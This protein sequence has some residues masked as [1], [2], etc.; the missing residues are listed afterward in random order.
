MT[1]GRGADDGDYDS[2]VIPSET[3]A[4]VGDAPLVECDGEVLVGHGAVVCLATLGG[5]SRLLG[6]GGLEWRAR[7]NARE[8]DARLAWLPRSLRDARSE[9]RAIHLF[10]RK[11]EA[12]PYETV[13][14]R[15]HLSSWG[16][17]YGR[18]SARFS[19]E[20]TL[21]PS[22]ALR[23]GH[24]PPPEHA[25]LGA[26]L[27]EAIQ[28][29]T[30]VGRR[31]A[32]ARRFVESWRGSIPS[33]VE[34]DPSIP[35]TVAVW[36]ALHAELSTVNEYLSCHPV[37]WTD[38]DGIWIFHR[39]SQSA[40]EWGVR[41]RDLGL[42]DPPVV[43]RLDGDWEDD[44]P[45]LSRWALGFVIAAEAF[46]HRGVRGW[47]HLDDADAALRR[48]TPMGLPDAHWPA[49]RSRVLVGARSFAIVS[50]IGSDRA[51][52]QLAAR[53]DDAFAAEVEALGLG[54]ARWEIAHG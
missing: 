1:A 54:D 50:G 2:R 39:E 19:F 4:V 38:D 15:A 17:P 13:G 24:P 16:G 34:L 44:A 52:I 8:P 46:N 21:S 31:F 12:S 26:P 33:R 23:L 29:A 20:V 10:V 3:R 48:L 7:A 18:E 28:S 51:Q 36:H 41:T 6:R 14:G 5:P 25:L 11:D 22:T 37:D 49:W 32:L 42:A 40:V 45:S 47:T 30:D 53:D 35:N 27:C 43:A 9:G